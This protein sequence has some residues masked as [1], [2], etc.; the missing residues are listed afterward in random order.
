MSVFIQLSISQLR[1]V[2]VADMVSESFALF[3]SLKRV[4]SERFILL[5]SLGTPTVVIAF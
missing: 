1:R 3:P 5:V 2:S 4:E